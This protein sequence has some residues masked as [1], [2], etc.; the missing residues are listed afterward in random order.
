MRIFLL[1][2]V[3]MSASV[4]CTRVAAKPSYPPRPAGCEVVLF[5][6]ESP[7]PAD[8]IGMV[9]AACEDGLPDADCIRRL[10]DEVCQA[11]GDV[12]WDVTDGSKVDLEKLRWSAHAGHT[13]GM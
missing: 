11:G 8:A 6:G 2:A 9:T 5:R 4:G 12:A 10:Q 13:R 3:L 1:L 7:V